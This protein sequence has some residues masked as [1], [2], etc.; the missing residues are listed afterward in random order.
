M[1]YMYRLKHLAIKLVFKEA[2]YSFRYQSLHS[3]K[4]PSYYSKPVVEEVQALLDTPCTVKSIGATWLQIMNVFERE[5]IKIV[6]LLLHSK[7]I[8]PHP[9]NRNGSMLNGFN[10]RANASKVLKVG[11]NRKELIG[12]VAIELSPFQAMRDAQIKANVALAKRSQG[13]IVDSSAI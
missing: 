1:S 2:S 9:T 8:M 6:T 4:M 13:L 5:K 12:A 11:A 3:C 7:E 10:A